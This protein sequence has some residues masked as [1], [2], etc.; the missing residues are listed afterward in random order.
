MAA[1][2]SPLS[3]FQSLFP[4][5]SS[6]SLPHPLSLS[7]YGFSFHLLCPVPLGHVSGPNFLC[8]L[9]FKCEC[10]CVYAGVRHLLPVCVEGIFSA[11]KE[12][13]RYRDRGN[14]CG[15][16]D[17]SPTNPAGCETSQL[18]D[19]T[20]LQGIRPFFLSLFSLPSFLLSL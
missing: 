1:L 8:G 3:I 10:V 2:I 9:F 12:K 7:A 11:A 20:S 16:F 6:L 18:S 15:V 4:L 5:P 13:T 17:I 19:L 14:L